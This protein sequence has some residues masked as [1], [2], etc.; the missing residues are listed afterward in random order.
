MFFFG[1][2]AWI[3]IRP[4]KMAAHHPTSI[5]VAPAP[6]GTTV[7]QPDDAHVARLRSLQ[8]WQVAYCRDVTRVLDRSIKAINM[9]GSPARRGGATMVGRAYTVSG[10]DI[11]LNALECA[12]PG[13]VYVHGG[14]HPRDAVMSPGFTHAYFARRGVAGVVVDGGVYK[15]YEADTAAMPIFAKFSSP[16]PAINR[17]EGIVGAAVVVGGV[18]I[19]PGDI[20]MGDLDGVIVIPRECEASLFAGL[21]GFLEANGKWGKIAA[22]AL[23]AGTVLTEEPA[24][25]AMFA[26]KHV[27]VSE[28]KQDTAISS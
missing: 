6:T 1:S 22:R 15:S 20:V 14:C 5:P 25:A 11:Y 7:P 26:R 24:L 4:T 3:R 8:T 18:S 17:K 19:Q 23:A 9:K 2:G 10:P 27:H 12:P 21:E 16:A 28:K 13:S